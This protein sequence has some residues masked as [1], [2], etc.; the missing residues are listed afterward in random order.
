MVGGNL[1]R[2]LLTQGCSVRALIHQDRRALE[3]L[4]VE[5][6]S[7]DLTN[8][9]SLIQAFTGA[10]TV[11]HLASSISIR[12]DNWD[13]LKQINVDGTQN[14]I[15]ACLHCGVQKLIYFSSIHAYQQEPY[16]QILDEDRPL[17]SG[18]SI[19]P[20]ERSKVAAERLARQAPDRGLTTITIIP[21]AIIG[22]ND[23]RPS[24]VGQAI[25]LLAS[26]HIPA[27]VHGGYDW[28]DVRDIVKGAR[29]AEVRGK[30]G[31][32]YIL[33]GHWHSLLD[34]ARISSKYTGIPAPQVVVPLWLAY[35]FQPIMAKLAHINNSQP[36]YT[37][38]M[39][40]AIRSNRL[41]SHAHA[42]HDLGYS[43]R[44]FEETIQDTIEWMTKR[45]EEKT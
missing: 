43:P 18:S 45:G 26:R 13:E 35:L 32:R 23:F 8:P 1:V 21:T 28:A 41:I 37:K 31:E 15:D 11:Y 19:P 7:A 20:Y 38:A 3:G 4:D 33:S 17:L 24:F 44:P 22:P 40:G 6:V 12:M 34:V 27:L 9:D 42:T 30:S 2:Y 29:Q 36:I 14:V 25:N 16:H 5:T 39:L 10:I